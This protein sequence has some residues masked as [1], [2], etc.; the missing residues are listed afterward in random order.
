MTRGFEAYENG[1]VAR[2]VDL[3]RQVL[4]MDPINTDAMNALGAVAGQSG[5]L[6][7]AIQQLENSLRIN[8]NQQTTWYNHGLTLQRIG[9]LRESL[10]SFD[11]AL[12]ID[13]SYGEARLQRA[14]SLTDLGRY[15]ESL[16]DYA[17]AERLMPNDPITVKQLAMALQWTGQY[18]RA[19]KEFDRSIALKPDHAEAWIGKAF[20][21]ML[22]GDLPGGFSLYEWRW[23]LDAWLSAPRR[24]RRTYPMPLWLGETSIEG[25]TILVYAEQGFGD[26]IQFCRYATLVALL[27]ARVILQASETLKSLMMTL[28]GPYEVISDIETMPAHDI[29]CPMMSLPLALGT[30]LETIPGDV[31]Y[32]HADPVRVAL[33]GKRVSGLRGRRIGL[34]WG[35]G[36]RV[37]DSAMV[38][39]EQRKSLPFRMLHPLAK[40]AGCSFIS[41]QLGPAATQITSDPGDMTLLDLTGDIED[42]AGTAALM[43][44]LDLVISVCTS[45]AHLAGALGKPVWL[46]NR[47]DT[48]WRW[49]LDREDSP[50]YP[51]MRIFRQPEPGDWASVVQNVVTAL[52]E[53]VAH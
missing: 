31:P 1:N 33:W 49:F 12:S 7:T 2:A 13:S 50:W 4:R 24:L 53:F 43:Q 16:T 18:E 8:P 38:A 41:L 17:D 30:T 29:C 35:A 51:T 34:V 47:F 44:N 6:L 45:T 36:S 11:R 5:D 27:G 48:D 3:F 42:F 9:M 20:L 39:I 26:E 15:Q 52:R 21:L 37:G 23:R 46:L 40:V 19:L 28:P 10:I 22:L 25:K 14:I 32:L